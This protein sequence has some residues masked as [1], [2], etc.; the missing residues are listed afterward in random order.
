M[1][2]P[3]TILPPHVLHP[4][5]LH[6]NQYVYAVLSRRSKGISIGVNL[7]PDKICNF[8]CIYCQVDRTTPPLLRDV[9]E[10]ALLRELSQTLAEWK[11]G[12]LFQG[13]NLRKVPEHLRRLNDIAFSGDGEPSTYPRFKEIVEK[14]AKLKSDLG[15]KDVKIV[16]ITNATMFHRPNVA[17]AIDIMM[18]NN[19]EVWAKLEAGTQEYYQFVE[20]TS[21]P[22][23]K[24]LDNIRELAK[25]H[26]VVIQ[27]L[28][29]KVNGAAPPDSEIAAYIERLKEILA[30]GGKLDRIQIYTVARQPAES[31]VAALEP[32]FVDEITAKVKSATGLPVESFY[33]S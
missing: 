12:S 5:T 24:V 29:M 19:G 11:D 4:R 9:D 8:D 22:L 28:F 7:N 27:S 16:L 10:D 2:N 17:A 15:F 3:I 33:G 13:E 6:E 23:S 18:A 25:R 31:Y 1:D 14:V 20:R 26:P 30:A 21:V 32:A